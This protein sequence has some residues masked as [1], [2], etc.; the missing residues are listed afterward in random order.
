MNHTETLVTGSWDLWLV[1]LSYVVAVFAAY[2]ALNLAGRVVATRG[3]ARRIWLAGGAF[4]MG[5]GIWAMHFTGMQAFKMPIPVTYDVPITLLSMVIAIAAS[6]LALFVVSRGVMRTP[7]LLIAGSVMG[8]GIASMHYTGMAAVQV[9][10]TISY[11]PFLFMLSVLIAIVASI[12]AL[13][14][15]FKFSIASN[16]GG[17]WRWTKGGSALVMGAA[18]VG[19]HYTGMAAANFVPTGEATTEM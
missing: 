4:A 19:M 2:T 10:G 7:Q 6:A 17:R 14:L 11:D 3:W 16:T 5:T 8:I 12:A 18:I 15:A 13:W 9:P 1:V